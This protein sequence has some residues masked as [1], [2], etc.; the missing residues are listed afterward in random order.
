MPDGM[1][2]PP[3]AKFLHGGAKN[4]LIGGAW[5]P[6]QSGLT[7][8]TVN[9]ATGAPLATIALAGA[10]DVD[11]AVAAARA[12]FE[13]PWSRI[14]PY[15]RQD[16]ILKLADLVGE[17][18][19]ELAYLDTLE[20]GGPIKRTLALKRRMMGMLRYYAGLATALHGET[21]QNSIPG[22]FL[23]YTLKEPVGVVGAII[24]WNG[25]LNL[26]IWKTG[27]VLATGCTLVLKPAQEASLVPL[28]FGELCLEAGFPEGVVNVIPG[29]GDAGSALAGHLG[30]DKLSFT[31]STETGQ[32]IIRASAGNIKRLSLELGGK[33]PNIVFADADLAKA[34]P[35]AAMGAFANSGQVCSAGTRLFVERRIHDEFVARLAA[36]SQTLTVGDPLD[37]ATDLGPLVSERQLGRVTGYL[38]A[39]HEEGAT[40]VIGGS[41]LAEGALAQ[42]YF[43]PPTVFTGVTATM[44]IAREEIFGPVLS[45]IPFDTVEEAVAGANA[46]PYG[47]GSGLWTRDVGRV[48]KVS[49]ALKAGMVWVNCYGLSD[50]AIPW[51]GYKMSGYGR[52]SG[53]QHLDEYLSVKAVLSNAD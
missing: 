25:P 39:G 52:E 1:T 46:T 31:G 16:L 24:P 5:V 28:R 9:P 19:E 30:V 12:A 8:E 48:Q 35:G 20:M 10:A 40:A 26:A 50:P 47:L 14:K 33:S 23:T 11:A 44:R 32:K 43:V 17:N 7:F 4:L 15:E 22:D 49:R 38:D 27:P 42:G 53:L 41:R 36:H 21:I 6:A 18:F 13:G 45:V 29:G 51:G 37:L 2:L 34:V 3:Q